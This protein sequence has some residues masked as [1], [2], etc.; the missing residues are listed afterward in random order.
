MVYRAD[1]QCAKYFV[2]GRLN[3]PDGA[4]SKKSLRSVRRLADLH[5]MIVER[6]EPGARAHA[7]SLADL[8]TGMLR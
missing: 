3:W 6:C 8:V 7:T 5:T 1:K 2:R 4:T